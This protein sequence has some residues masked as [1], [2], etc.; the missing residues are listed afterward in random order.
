MILAGSSVRREN[1]TLLAS[2]V[3]GEL[4]A[5]LR[6]AVA[7]HNSIVA[8]SVTDRQQIITALA[9]RP[10]QFFELRTV[11]VAQ[12]A[13]VKKIDEREARKRC[14][15]LEHDRSRR[16]PSSATETPRTSP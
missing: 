12:L 11:L 9:E 1:V 6:R 2:M 3:D 14:M 8:L 5:K 4:A 13:R 7:N 15:K 16:W 10:A